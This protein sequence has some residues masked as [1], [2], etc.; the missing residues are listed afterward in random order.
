[1]LSIGRLTPVTAHLFQK[2]SIH[3]MRKSR[4][5]KSN[6]NTL[7][8]IHTYAIP[9]LPYIIS[10]IPIHQNGYHVFRAPA[11]EPHQFM[12]GNISLRNYFRYIL[13]NLLL[14]NI[15]GGPKNFRII[16]TLDWRKESNM[17]GFRVNKVVVY[18]TY[19]ILLKNLLL[20][21]Y[22]NNYYENVT[23]GNSCKKKDS[24]SF[25]VAQ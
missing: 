23:L 1:M 21:V 17:R 24:F 11:S 16:E 22:S 10:W 12:R 3:F 15:V 13:I 2:F 7:T 5:T 18:I 14:E 20:I 25:V 8:H 19:Y 9:G 6:V 4:T